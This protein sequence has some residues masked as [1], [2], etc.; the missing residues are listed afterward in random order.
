MA[1]EENLEKVYKAIASLKAKGMQR[2]N[3]ELVRKIAGV[4]R[5]TIYLKDEDWKEVRDVIAG[6]DSERL[7]ATALDV[8]IKS[9]SALAIEELEKR[10]TEAESELTRITSVADKVYPELIDEIQRWFVA[11]SETPNNK[12]KK[13]HDAAE[14][15]K[16]KA[17]C[18]RLRK[19]NAS[20]LAQLESPTNMRMLSHKKTIILKDGL[21]AGEFF[22]SFM[23]QL[24]SITSHYLLPGRP[25]ASYILCS[26]NSNF[27]DEWIHNH[28]PKSTGLNLY[29]NSV[30]GTSD[31][32][33]F[34]LQQ[35]RAMLSGEIHCVLMR[36]QLM[37]DV[38]KN[39]RHTDESAKSRFNTEFFEHP[40]FDEPFD[41]FIII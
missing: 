19:E 6:K 8:N 38:G 40:S 14:L 17:E 7:A 35:I 26:L 11:A 2:L 29:I 20:M 10:L 27:R 25:A 28:E 24:Q 30:A 39:S 21:T 5:S 41:S 4:A 33:L 1:N 13:V 9:A 16:L 32:R 34:F 36:D 22:G 23:N 31:T 37:K 18:E 15:L 12:K 3:V